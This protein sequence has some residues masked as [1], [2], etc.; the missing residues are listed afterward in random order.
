MKHAQQ[1]FC[2]KQSVCIKTASDQAFPSPSD[3]AVHFHL[4]IQSQINSPFQGLTLFKVL[5]Q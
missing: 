4:L 5:L 3:S 2:Q 1:D